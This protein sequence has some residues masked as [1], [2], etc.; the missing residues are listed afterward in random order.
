MVER[1]SNKSL[2]LAR[3][4]GGDIHHPGHAQFHILRL[5]TGSIIGGWTLV[6]VFLALG[7]MGNI[8][9][10]ESMDLAI[11][12]VLYGGTILGIILGLIFSIVAAL[13]TRI[14]PIL[15]RTTHPLALVRTGF[16]LLIVWTFFTYGFWPHS[17]LGYII[18]PFLAFLAGLECIR[19]NPRAELVPHST[20]GRVL[21]TAIG[22]FIIVSMILL[23]MV[24]M[25]QRGFGNSNSPKLIIVAVDGIDGTLTEEFLGS[26]EKERY[27]NLV[28]MKEN[29]GIGSL[30][31]TSPIISDR[32]WADL[33]T[34]QDWDG[35]GILDRHSTSDDLTALTMW[36]I[37][38]MNGYRIGL[39]QMLPPHETSP[40]FEF[41]IP[42][43]GTAEEKDS[44]S[45]EALTAVRIIGR[46]PGLAGV[47]E[48]I[49]AACQ[50]ARLGVTLE[51]ITLIAGEYSLELLT[52]QHYSFSYL[53]RKL[54]EF[55]VES[56]IAIS[57]LNNY[58]VDA[59]FLRFT[60]LEDIFLTYWGYS[61]P[62]AFGPIQEGID[63]AVVAGLTNAIPDAVSELDRLVVRLKPFIGDQTVFAILSNHGVRS[64]SDIRRQ[65]YF[66]SP[67]RLIEILGQPGSMI[68]DVSSNGIV[69]R[70]PGL[71]TSTPELTEFETLLNETKWTLE[72][73]DDPNNFLGQ[74]VF[75]VTR[76]GESL[77][78]SLRNSGGINENVWIK[79]SMQSANFIGPI[80][81][82]D[83]V[84][85]WEGRLSE[86]L[87][88]GEQ[89]SGRINGSALM[90]INGPQ[91]KAGS[92]ASN[93][94]LFDVTAT[95]LHAL[96]FGISYDILGH[97][98]DELFRPQWLTNHPVIYVENYEPVEPE[99][100]ELDQESVVSDDLSTVTEDAVEISAVDD[101]PV[102]MSLFREWERIE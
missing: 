75:S 35:H 22:P 92:V 34:G 32:A 67:E 43:S 39:F 77:E 91:F 62:P 95:I 20:I 48:S 71:D 8:E 55:R 14:F 66:L 84:F 49:L 85:G 45:S 68:G 83:P 15:R 87:A 76:Y 93:P 5:L 16:I 17:K 100:V 4:P 47:E 89:P 51:T 44:L 64:T 13:L 101:E 80:D 72:P 24:P 36:D 11:N 27:P 3:A 96:G 21:G 52:D 2:K 60:S 53:Q 50:L 73:P 99:P 81:S 19:V 59:A 57:R 1:H 10:T 38:A 56:D 46:N 37:L 30:A 12:W 74:R 82:P 33:M 61:K 25:F 42:A 90:M 23:V 70:I 98:L 6:L 63:S 7:F 65:E 41:D 79:T 78:I 54:L 29:G 58:P 88:P 28:E 97:T 86:L 26:N 40:D 94:F 31:A 9:F 18:G 69:I 102:D